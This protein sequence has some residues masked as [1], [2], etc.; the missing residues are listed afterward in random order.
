MM[1]EAEAN[2]G[3]FAPKSASHSQ[4]IN[5]DQSHLPKPPEETG[6]GKR[7][8]TGSDVVMDFGVNR[9]SVAGP[10]ESKA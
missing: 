2:W 5:I 7:N 1:E 6:G 3:T 8:V 9:S 4:Q 10:N